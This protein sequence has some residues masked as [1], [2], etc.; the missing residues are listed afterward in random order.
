MSAPKPEQLARSA[1]KGANTNVEP[2]CRILEPLSLET[3]R[4]PSLT[5]NGFAVSAEVM[6]V[7][8]RHQA[9]RPAGETTEASTMLDRVPR[10]RT[11][12]TL[13]GLLLAACSTVAA[14]PSPGAAPPTDYRQIVSDGDA[15]TILRGGNRAKLPSEERTTAEAP[16]PKMRPKAPSTLSVSLLRKTI[17]TELGDWFTCLKAVRGGSV[18]YYGISFI[19]AEIVEWR[20]AVAVDHC[21]QLTYGPLPAPTK[22]PKKGNGNGDRDPAIKPRQ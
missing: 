10:W 8:R 13:S 5:V 4:L 22:K 12:W 1:A 2:N 6:I 3:P 9:C 21:E 16:A 18:S 15:A 17:A 20:P 19:G 11:S 14:Q 7:D